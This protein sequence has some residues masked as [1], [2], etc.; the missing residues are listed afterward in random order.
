MKLPKK[1]LCEYVDFNVSDEEFVEKMMWRGFELGGME[2]ELSGVTGVV[3][4]RVV[5]I[6]RHTNSDHL[7]VCQLD[8]GTKHEG[9]LQI[10]TGADN[11]IAGALVPVA[12]V[13]ATLGGRT[14]ERVVMR[15][16][17]SSGM[18]C[19]GKE[20][21]LTDADYPGSEIHGIL[22]LQ[23][24]YP[25]GVPIGEALGFD[26]VIFD[27][28]LTPNRPDC[29]SIL[30]LVREAAA[31]LGQSFAEPKI[32]T[33]KGVGRA[34]D[35][36]RVTVDN[37]ALCPRYTARVVKD[38]KIAPSPAW[39]QKRLRSV[40]L[41]PINNIVDITNYVLIEYGHPMHAFD[42]RCVKD[43]HIVV[44]SARE[45]EIVTTLDGKARAVTP[46]MLLIADPEKGVGVAGVMGGENSEITE[47][48]RS[49]L[50]ESAVFVGSNIRATARKLR[51]TTDAAARFIK[52]VEPVN[53]LLALERAIE[54]VDELGAGTVVGGTID[55]CA[56]ELSPRKVNID[57][58]HVN[59]LLNLDLSPRE[60]ADM[61]ETI[62]ISARPG[63]HS[64]E[65][66]IPHFR[67]DIESGVEADWDIAEEVARLY[68]YY[69]IAPTLMRG[70]TFRGAVGPDFA[71]EDTVKDTLAACGA[72]EM[73]NYNFTGPAQLDAL[74]LPPED[75]RRLA[76]RIQNPFGEDQ[77][78]MRTTL[79]SGLLDSA[80]RNINRRSEQGRFFEVGNVHFNNNDLLPE[81]R[82]L[83]GLIFFGENESFFTLKGAVETL[84]AACGVENARWQAVHDP[85]FQPGRAAAVLGADGTR[86]GVMGDVHPAVC[87][88]YGV[89]G[90]A[91]AA[92]LSFAAVKA[93][94]VAV[95]KYKALPRFPVVLRDL[96]VVVDKSAES[97]ALSR[98]IETADAGV[99]VENARLFDTYAG[100]GVPLGKKS[101]A[102]TFTLRAEDHT[103]DDAEIKRAM[104]A[105]I[106]ALAASGAPLRV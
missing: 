102:F 19:S 67:T 51:H 64:L 42:L 106:E 27:F 97:A 14:M 60:M 105:V 79:L 1:W 12:L 71:L 20:L 72:Y 49:V 70:D 36:A 5:S 25:L 91:Y 35:Y 66:T 95:K 68:G 63:V 30:G 23:E 2:R 57:T 17:E 18:L 13:G 55:V 94:S 15:G 9:L 41:R 80:A 83:I 3:T 104:N 10:V 58:R 84:L 96:A 78:L 92:E 82:K 99:L 8:V 47:S 53:A 74:N 52:G 73:Y 88:A 46:D 69:N 39:M 65:V 100:P 26:D 61:L 101:L 24:D 45:K 43:G 77:S 93:L 103:L 40:G 90:R 38:I 7:W 62:H 54:L 33:I 29:A 6:E 59:A 34:E 75:E 4:G 44:R 76:V 32:R 98:V 31:A 86:I 11:V 16:V 50:F 37:P 48:T 89:D 87:R 28:E 85:C 81:E 21:G 22:L 56:S